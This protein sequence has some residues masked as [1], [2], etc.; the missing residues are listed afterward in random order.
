MEE[1]ALLGG[2]PIRT[3]P[4]PWP[5]AGPEEV[6]A[7]HGVVTSG[8]WGHAM[9]PE[10]QVTMFEREFAEHYGIGYAITT[11]SGS[12][13]LEVALRTVAVGPGDE[14]IT[15]ALT[16]VAPQLAAVMVGADPV[17]VDV[18]PATY[19]LD[20]S[21]IE[22]AITPRTK[23]IIPVHIGGNPCD[24]DRIMSIA[25]RHDLIVIEDCAQAHGSRY[26]GRL[27]GTIGHLGCFSFEKSKL[28]TAGE[29]G[30][31]ITNDSS[32]GNGAYRFVN[33]GMGYGASAMV[34][35]GVARWNLR[36]TEFQAAILRVQLTRLEVERA[37]RSS[38]AAV[39]D[40]HISLIPGLSPLECASAQNY[41]SYVFKYDAAQFSGVPVEMFREALKAEG[42]PCF[43]SASHQLS[44]HPTLFHSPRKSYDGVRLAVAEKARYHEAVGIH[45]TR[46]LLDTDRG[47]GD[48]VGAIA[49]VTENIERLL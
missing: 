21:G 8:V 4:F 19:C 31:V 5:L 33:T 7:V 10:C 28:M 49:K 26:K 36:M 16:W 37:T 40:E 2:P 23:A 17:F 46:A 27:T 42:L 47:I 35:E 18:K 43:S 34:P 22:A 41:Y 14:V 38:H 15:P 39:L 12:T 32:W 48:I 3:E 6:A 30:M 1:L 29:G 11:T 9:S 24:M 45:A 44:Y 20:P 13:A 25:D